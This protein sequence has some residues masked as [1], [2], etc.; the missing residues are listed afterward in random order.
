MFKKPYMSV[1]QSCPNKRVETYRH[2]YFESGSPEDGNW[3]MT[4]FPKKFV[5]LTR[6]TAHC[7]KCIS[8][9][10]ATKLA[11]KNGP[12]GQA[13][14]LSTLTKWQTAQTAV[15]V[16][17][18]ERTAVPNDSCIH[19]LCLPPGQSRIPL[20]VPTE[21]SKLDKRDNCKPK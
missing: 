18:V 3:H 7:S 10:E 13:G 5:A 21:T 20:L 4:N 16:S 14:T 11:Q 8:M 15:Q 19:H 2:I 17:M 9:R 12:L 1:T 6:T